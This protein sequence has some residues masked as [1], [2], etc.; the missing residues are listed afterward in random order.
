MH[1]L[2]D[3]FGRILDGLMLVAC[4]LLLAMAVMIGADVVTRNA[5]LGGIAWSGEVSE[6]IIYL[7][8]LMA[9]PWLLRQGQHIRVD[10][11]LRALPGRTAWALEWAGDIL[12]L[13]CSLYFVWYGWAVLAASYRAGAITP[14]GSAYYIG[15]DAATLQRIDLDPADGGGPILG[16]VSANHPGG[17]D[18]AIHPRDGRVY[19]LS[20]SVESVTLADDDY[21]DAGKLTTTGT[22][23]GLA[24][25]RNPG[26]GTFYGPKIDVDIQDALARRWQV[27][28]VQID[29]QQPER[30]GLEYIDTDGQPKR[31]VMI[32]RAIFGS[33]ERFVG[34]LTEH[35]AGAFP[36]W[37]APVQARVIPISEK[38]GAYARTVYERLRA[39]RIRAELDDRNEKLGYRIREAQ[40]RKVPYML[41]CG[42][43]EAEAGTVS[44]RHRS[45]DDVGAVPLDRLVAELG[46]EIS[47]REP[48]LTVGRS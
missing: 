17:L 29:F 3:A 27:A 10:I 26:D 42:A 47:A 41:V 14:D 1:R 45:G 37:L 25:E 4:L 8:T 20:T 24:F 18:F 12:G 46:R 9:A 32:H 34:I 31:P 35:Y 44:L 40:L 7:L 28:T 19:F 13:A 22:A 21:A 39:A 6:N 23:N 43:R 48:S 5:G 2:S 36:T 16:A 15:G 38:F 11:L 33:F 30:F